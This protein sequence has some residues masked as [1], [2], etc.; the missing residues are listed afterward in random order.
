MSSSIERPR[1]SSSLAIFRP[2]LN[3]WSPLVFSFQ[4]NFYIPPPFFAFQ[5]GSFCLHAPPARRRPLCFLFYFFPPPRCI[6]RSRSPISLQLPVSLLTL[7]HPPS[8]PPPKFPYSQSG[9]TP[10][11]RRKDRP[12][13][14]LGARLSLLSSL[15]LFFSL[16][17]FDPQY[18]GPCDQLFQIPFPP[19]PTSLPKKIARCPLHISEFN[20]RSTISGQIGSPPPC[21]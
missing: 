11:H 20:L 18:R 10:S 2:P 1:P 7:P 13:F 15:E 21:D 9:V 14:F 8:F 16:F 17:P 4:I 19:S 3:C 6:L 5:K 12:P